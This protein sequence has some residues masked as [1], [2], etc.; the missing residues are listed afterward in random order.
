MW[1]ALNCSKVHFDDD[2]VAESHEKPG[3]GVPRD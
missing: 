3:N 2:F 1:Q